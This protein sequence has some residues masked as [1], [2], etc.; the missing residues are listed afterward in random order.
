MKLEDRIRMLEKDKEKLIKDNVC[1]I[2]DNEFM[3]EQI[4][5]T[6]KDEQDKII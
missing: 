6:L 4:N 5:T 3:K 2:R 1:L